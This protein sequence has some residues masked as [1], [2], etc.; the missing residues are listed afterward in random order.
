M[1]DFT[2]TDPWRVFRIMAE[3]VEGFDELS[4]LGPAVSVFGSA[5]ATPE[6][7]YY[8]RA[9]NVGR[10]LAENGFAVVTGGG[11]G[12]MGAA[13][14]GAKEAGGASVGLNILL[15]E[16]Q[17][18]NPY[19]TKLLSF[20]YFFVRKLMFSK[21]SVGF[22]IF[23]GGFGTMDEMFESL[24]LVQTRR[25]GKSSFPICLFGSEF[26]APLRGWLRETLLARGYVAAEDLE[27][28][29]VTDDEEEAVEF[30]KAKYDR[31]TLNHFG[32]M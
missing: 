22:V 8:A 26:W 23:P 2:R 11:P 27:L 12:I 18:A 25:I 17:R 24:T 21:H 4:R 29:F 15:P 16:E 7:A 6:D 32:W 30:I 5:K 3:F 14:K 13:N 10:L 1:D 28:F 9:V 19:V 31:S 20:R